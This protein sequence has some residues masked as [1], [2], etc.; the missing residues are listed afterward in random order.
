M[1]LAVGAAS[2][3]GSN[4]S[5]DGPRSSLVRQDLPAD[6]SPPLDLEQWSFLYNPPPPPPREI[7]KQD[8][9]TIRVNELERIQSEGEIQRRKNSSIDLRLRDWLR[10]IGIDTIKPAE[11]A[12]GEP[13]IRASD[14]RIFRTQ[15]ELETSKRLDF[16]IT[17][18]V[19]DIRPN[20]TLVLEAHRQFQID[21]EVWE[22]SLTGICRAEDVGPDNVVLSRN[23]SDLH[24]L[25]RERGHIRDSYKRGA[26]TRLLDRFSP[27]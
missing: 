11:F 9:I 15:G 18:K 8:L 27:F 17:A 10:L 3:G 26:I 12:D 6:E 24:V 22:Y 23:I 19:A 25:K 2:V 14:D 20:G 16:N 13:R 5:A 7:R 1:A 4:V 21:N